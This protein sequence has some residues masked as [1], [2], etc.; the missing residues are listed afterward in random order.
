MDRVDAVITELEN[1]RARIN[2]LRAS[3]IVL[4]EQLPLR[5]ANTGRSIT[6]RESADRVQEDMAQ[7][8][9]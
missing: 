2:G 6:P 8:K 4:K 9:T 5:V 7:G 1:L 3:L